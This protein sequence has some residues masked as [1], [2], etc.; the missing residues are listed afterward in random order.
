VGTGTEAGEIAGRL[1]QNL[2]MWALLPR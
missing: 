2:N 1:K